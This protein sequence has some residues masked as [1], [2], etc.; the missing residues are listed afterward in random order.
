[1]LRVA[2]K[3]GR[4]EQPTLLVACLT[5]NFQKLITQYLGA[6]RKHPK[7][8]SQIQKVILSIVANIQS[9][10][11]D[12]TEFFKLLKATL[13]T[14]MIHCFKGHLPQLDISTLKELVASLN[15]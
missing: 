2:L 14:I 6:L 12:K 11:E 15:S 4:K 5:K 1:M 7:N 8:A 3:R 13:K 9:S 10:E